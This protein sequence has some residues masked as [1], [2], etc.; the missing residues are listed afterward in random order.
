MVCGERDGGVSE[1]VGTVLMVAVVVAFAG[2]A[3]VM[4][5]GIGLP[6]EP[7]TLVV[8][9]TR[10][11][12]VITFTNHGGMNM[13]KVAEVHCWIGGV[14]QGNDNFPLGIQAGATET[15]EAP[16]PIRVVVVG[17]FVDGESWIVLDKTL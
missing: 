3:G 7:K 8:T 15:C 11:G 17:K 13:D 4:V 9:A 10:S 16:G 14:D 1:V 6:E 2:I 5:F 12:D